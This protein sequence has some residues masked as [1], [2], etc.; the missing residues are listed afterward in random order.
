GGGCYGGKRG[1][2]SFQSATRPPAARGHQLR[3]CH[4]PLCDARHDPAGQ[5]DLATSPCTSD[6]E[7]AS[8]FPPQCPKAYA[9]SAYGSRAN[10]RRKSRRTAPNRNASRR[11]KSET[12]ASTTAVAMQR[13]A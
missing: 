8:G 12:R 9:S 5:L 2:L 1:L 7:P 3:L 11:T 6:G 4:L 10:G 13:N